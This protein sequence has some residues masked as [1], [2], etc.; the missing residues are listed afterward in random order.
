M[1]C[2]VSRQIRSWCRMCRVCT[3]MT[4]AIHR[5]QHCAAQEDKVTIKLRD[6]HIAAHDHKAGCAAQED[7]ALIKLRD[8]H[9]A[10]QQHS[11]PS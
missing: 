11:T 10:A 4:E 3:S 1:G 2:Y 6:E 8:E 9:V 5:D 7:N